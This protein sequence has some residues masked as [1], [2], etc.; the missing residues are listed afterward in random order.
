MSKERRFISGPIKGTKLEIMPSKAATHLSNGTPILERCLEDKNPS[1]LS[2]TQQA[3]LAG[4]VNVHEPQ[5][6]VIKEKNKSTRYVG[7]SIAQEWKILY[8]GKRPFYQAVQER[9]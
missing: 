3:A 9:S 4:K 1:L 2:S 6:Y 5:E 7:P 8:Q